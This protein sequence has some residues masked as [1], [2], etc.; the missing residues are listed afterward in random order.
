[1]ITKIAKF[2]KRDAGSTAVEFAFFAIPMSFIIIGMVEI[3]MM[4]TAGT[5]LQ[6]GTDGAA[7]LIRTG[8]A[9]TSGDPE[10]AFRNKLCDAVDLMVDC[11]NLIYEVI[12]VPDDEGFGDVASNMS[13]VDPIYDANNDLQPRGFDSGAENSL[14]VV[15]VA[16]PYPLRTP[17][18]GPF[19]AES[20]KTTRLLMA[21]AIIQNEPYEF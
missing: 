1:M 21:T 14:I 12:R 15:R 11:D 3:G 2:F 20:G 10:A 7:R 8:Q 13:Q 9:Q 6:G 18:V 19:L 5:L 17:F 4:S 16:Y